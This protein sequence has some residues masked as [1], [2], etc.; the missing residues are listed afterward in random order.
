[1]ESEGVCSRRQLIKERIELAGKL[2]VKAQRL[3][4][5]SGGIKGFQRIERK[6]KAENNFLESVSPM[7]HH[8]PRGKRVW[9]TIVWTQSLGQEKNRVLQPDCRWRMITF[10]C[11]FYTANL[12]EDANCI[13][14]IFVI[15]CCAM[16]RGL[17]IVSI[18]TRPFP[19]LGA[20]SGHETVL[21]VDPGERGTYYFKGML[22]LIYPIIT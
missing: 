7:S 8:S 20:G 4:Q 1:M 9:Q 12:I 6:I 13:P 18:S 21:A 19:P 14:C 22:F 11:V 17:S 15:K 10:Q 5:R 2:L 3:K 16:V